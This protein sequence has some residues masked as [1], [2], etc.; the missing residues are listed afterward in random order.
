M[1]DR[2]S[3]RQAILASPDDD[4][5]RLVFA[6][7]LD[8]H[9]N[10]D[11]RVRAAFIRQSCDLARMEPWGRE[12]RKLRV[13]VN[14]LL[15]RN[16][17]KWSAGLERQA[18]HVRFARGFV[19]EVTVYS[20]RFVAEGAKLFE[21]EPFR[22][23]KFVDVESGRGAASPR[24]L[25]ASPNLARLHTLHLVGRGIGDDFIDQ[26]IQSPHAS[27]LCGLRLQGCKTSPARLRSILDS[28]RLPHLTELDLHGQSTAEKMPTVDSDHLKALLKS[29]NFARLKILDLGNTA[30]GTDGIR[31]LA[32]CPHAAGLEVLRLGF[33]AIGPGPLRAEGAEILPQSPHL[34]NLR[35]LEIRGH[36]LRKKGSEAF[37]R[38]ANWPKLRRLSL[39]GNDIPAKSLP[40]FAENASLRSLVE[41]DL[42]GNKINQN[43]T[44]VLQEALPE[45]LILTDDILR[46][47]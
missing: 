26:L 2:D 8:E 41:L 17:K 36:E 6:D 35:E 3:L 34:V 39:R 14:K 46:F 47:W 25:F 31:A 42:E 45:T 10:A 5:P 15:G 29:P 27:G 32:N 43:D 38:S 24:D 44:K 30:V 33:G 21:I 28:P 7:W 4:T 20:K 37:A 11:D 12:Y 13:Q 40:V 23:V 9:G 19:E 22:A 1:T 18:L 16:E